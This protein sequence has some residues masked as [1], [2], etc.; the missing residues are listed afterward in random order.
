MTAHTFARSWIQV[1]THAPGQTPPR[2]YCTFPDIGH[3]HLRIS[4]SEG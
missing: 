3:H 1:L 4:P 2:A